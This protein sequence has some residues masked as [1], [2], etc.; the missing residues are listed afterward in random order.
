[1]PWSS[2]KERI[3]PVK[4]VPWQHLTAAIYAPGQIRSDGA[5]LPDHYTIEIELP[6]QALA[7][8]LLTS[9]NFPRAVANLIWVLTRMD[10]RGEITIADH[11]RTTAY[12]NITFRPDKPKV[13]CNFSMIARDLGYRQAHLAN[14]RWRPGGPLRGLADIE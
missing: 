8:L 1:M 13:T 2:Q 11:T 3:K 6:V 5:I 9:T 4:R 7:S 10:Y 12:V 14:Q